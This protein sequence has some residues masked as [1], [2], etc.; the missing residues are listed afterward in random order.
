MSNRIN[1]QLEEILCRFKDSGVES[2]QGISTYD[3][4]D[5]LKLIHRELT[6]ENGTFDKSYQEIRDRIGTYGEDINSLFNKAYDLYCIGKL[7]ES[8]EIYYE[9]LAECYAKKRWILY[10]FAQI[11]LYYLRQTVI[12][13]DKTNK[14]DLGPFLLGT[15]D[16]LWADESIEE[17]QL[18]QILTDVPSELKGYAFANKLIAKN[19]YQ[20]DFVKLYQENYDIEMQIANRVSEE[21]GFSKDE[22]V[23]ITLFDAV[24]FIYCNKLAFDRFKEHKNFLKIALRQIYKGKIYRNQQMFSRDVDCKSYIN[25]SE[26]LLMIRNFDY[27]ELVAFYEQEQG[28]M[29][30]LNTDTEGKFEKYILD[31]MGYFRKYFSN[32][33]NTSTKIEYFTLKYEIRNAL[34][35]A[36]FYV[37]SEE[38]ICECLVYL[39]QFLP[40]GELVLDA[41][42][43]MLERF[44]E[45]IKDKG[46]ILSII[47]KDL[48]ERIRRCNGDSSNWLYNEELNYIIQEVNMINKWFIGYKSKNVKAELDLLDD[49]EKA[50]VKSFVK[51]II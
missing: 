12:L 49:E 1:V 14:S 34:F 19:Y 27:K 29:L 44:K 20:E 8:M 2:I 36:S 5:F 31:L 7:D 21:V 3:D 45:H 51:I 28:S 24:N 38:I 40:Y 48:I 23:K 33:T 30:V 43:T 42:V 37:R 25:F 26:V 22:R 50:K 11:N 35:L 39:F 17:M 10:F 47:E 46:V 13:L 6:I 18:S 15:L 9:V 32:I 41:R 4:K 16:K